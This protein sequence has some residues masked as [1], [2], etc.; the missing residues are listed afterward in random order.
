MFESN[1][2]AIV[3]VAMIGELHRRLLEKAKIDEQVELQPRL[4]W[5][6]K[7]IRLVVNLR[8]QPEPYPDDCE[9]GCV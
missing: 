6:H 4:T 3:G 2:Y 5:R 9:I 7:L 8:P 1:P